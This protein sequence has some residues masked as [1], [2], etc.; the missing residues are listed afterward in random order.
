MSR[1]DELIK[2]CESLSES[3]RTTTTRLV[4]EI[5][6]LE[7]QLSELKTKPFI[8][9]H[10]SDPTQQK[11]TPSAKLYKELL[12]QYN[13]CIKILLSACGKTGESEETSPLREYLKRMR[14]AE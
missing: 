13:N 9:Y 14:D 8:K 5:V 1:K 11:A 4:D 3:T 2:L 7:E 10:P 12:Q 6:F